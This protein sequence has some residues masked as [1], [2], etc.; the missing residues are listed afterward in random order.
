MCNTKNASFALTDNNRE[1]ILPK[2][3]FTNCLQNSKQLLNTQSLRRFKN[4]Y[5]KKTF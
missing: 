5:G 3:H 1:Q 4:K 2:G